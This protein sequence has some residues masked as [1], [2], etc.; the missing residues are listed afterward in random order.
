LFK[1]KLDNHMKLEFISKPENVGFARTVIAMFASQLDFT[2]DEIEEIK[3][4]VSEMVSNCIIHGYPSRLGIIRIEAGLK[5]NELRILISDE[6][7]GIKDIEWA[8]QPANTTQPD[9]RMGLG[10][11]FAKEYMDEFSIQSSYGKGTS[12]YMLKKVRPN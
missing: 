7:V 6:G 5:E 2:I 12:V 11:V 1:D 4:A 3:V 8:T 10:F 9:E